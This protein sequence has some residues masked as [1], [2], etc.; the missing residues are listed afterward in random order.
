M[1]SLAKSVS[2]S[3]GVYFVPAFS[4][5][6][7]PYWD[8]SARGTICGITQDTTKGHLARA[9]LESVCFQTA[10]MLDA[11]QRDSGAE[12]KELRVGNFFKISFS[13]IIDFQ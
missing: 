5:L 10:E 1:E 3:G 6:F 8:P 2:D 13:E 7:S 11:I 4:G 12:M 9:T